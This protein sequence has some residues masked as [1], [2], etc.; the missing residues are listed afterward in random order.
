[1]SYNGIVFSDDGK[2]IYVSQARD[3][4]FIA[5]MGKDNVLTWV[6]RITFSKPKVGGHPVPGGI[7]LD[8]QNEKLYTKLNRSNSLAIV[9]LSNNSIKE[10]LVG[11]APYEVLLYSAQ[12]AYV[13]NWGGRNPNPGEVT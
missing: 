2:K 8:E 10:I 3:H 13:S 6:D 11:V 9:K 5:E 7:I 1:G 4:I 12:K